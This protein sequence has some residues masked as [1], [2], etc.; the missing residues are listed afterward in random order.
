MRTVAIFFVILAGS[1]AVAGRLATVG[2]QKTSADALSAEQTP[3]EAGSAPAASPGGLIVHEWGTFTSFSGS[4]G[5]PVGFLPNNSDL[6]GFVYHHQADPFAKAFTKSDW[7]QRYGTVS[8]E[9]PVMYFYAPAETRVSVRVDFPGGWITEW[10]PHAATAPDEKA[11]QP[12]S[13][14]S[15]QGGETIRWEVSLR[16]GETDR[17]PRDKLDNP[18]YF[19]RETDAVP[20]QTSFVVPAEFA[21]EPIGGGDVTQRE[22]FLF[23]RG[24][25][26]FAP[27]VTVQA[28]GMGKVRVANASG[29]R[30]TGLVLA[31]VH[32]GQLAFRAVSELERDGEAVAALPEGN[33]NPA[34][35]GALVE[36]EL[37]A[38]GL[39]PR[40]AKAMVKTWDHAWFREEGTRLLYVLPR[41]R[42]D[43][44]LPLKVS[45]QPTE[46]V[47]VIV[48][49]H[50]FLTPEQESIAVQQLQRIRDAQ[51]ELMAAQRKQS[52][53]E[54]E[55]AK[56]G[57]FSQQAREMAAHLLETKATK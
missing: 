23:Y 20:L 25:G 48:G 45:P 27:P 18:Y 46:L 22:K 6:P 41:T 7:L 56:L 4:N 5:R 15:K 47:R 49:R 39:Y 2:A 35:L 30:V 50:D 28:L 17:F 9:T 54:V 44:L 10:H 1:A 19:A 38:A 33:A 34:E 55:M 29:G 24:V 51:V 40:E 13:R 32:D 16:P 42:T 21:S 26:T 31:T 52:A 43:E 36:R 53:A 37:I 8:M 12:D 57:R 11:S 3:V 14:E